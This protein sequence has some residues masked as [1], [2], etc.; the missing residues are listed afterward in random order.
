MLKAAAHICAN[1]MRPV[2]E[3]WAKFGRKRSWQEHTPKGG[4][5][6]SS[7]VI[8]RKGDSV[9]MGIPKAS[10]AWPEK[11]G[12]P[13]FA[14]KRLEKNRSWLL[15]S[16]PLLMEESP[17]EAAN[18]VVHEWAGLEGQP[19]FTGIQ[20]HTHD[21]GRVEGYNHWDICFL[22]EMKANALPDKKAWWS[23]VR[24][25]PISEVRKLKIGRG[26]RDVL[27]MAGYI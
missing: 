24:F 27:E 20:S 25:I 16:T 13:K 8:V 9:L 18:R 15:P 7:F 19:R 5:C 6:L 3:R 22:Y 11:G 2:S 1:H 26:H 17:D 14:A 12:Y 21:S 23:E 4:V 10:K